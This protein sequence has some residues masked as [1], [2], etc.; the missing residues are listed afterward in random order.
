MIALVAREDM[1]TILSLGFGRVIRGC[2]YLD[3]S[4]LLVDAAGSS[5][6]DSSAFLRRHHLQNDWHAVSI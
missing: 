2:G 1:E 4:L 3:M 5:L 6:L